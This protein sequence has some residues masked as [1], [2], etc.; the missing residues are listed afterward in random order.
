MFSMYSMETSCNFEGKFIIEVYKYFIFTD[1]KS[2][3]QASLI[4][5]LTVT[6]KKTVNK[7]V[8]QR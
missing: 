7:L 2:F 8:Y 1:L 6:V 3:I 4:R 5:N